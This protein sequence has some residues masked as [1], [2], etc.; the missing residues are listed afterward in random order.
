MLRLVGKIG[1]FVVSATLLTMGQTPAAKSAIRQPAVAKSAD[2]VRTNSP[3]PI[4]QMWPEQLPAQAPRVTY[5]NGLLTVDSQNSTLGDILTAI[6]RQTGAELELPPGIGSERVAAHFSGPP[7]D[8]LTSLLDGS[9][10]G[11]IILGSADNPSQVRKVILSLLPK[12]AGT[13]PPSS[14][15]AKPPAPEPV[16]EDQP[17]PVADEPQIPP[18]A[19]GVPPPLARPGQPGQPGVPAQPNAA[20][21]ANANAGAS[22]SDATTQGPPSQTEDSAKPKTPDQYL[23][24]LRQMH[25]PPQSPAQ[26]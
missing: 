26:Q 13:P 7:R 10:V 5:Q 8:V 15:Q 11:Y 2:A 4:P 18:P 3:R 12:D 6:R 14:A 22:P 17:D 24:Q 19:R 25:P 9:S 20:V 16:D 21:D 23:Q 1:I